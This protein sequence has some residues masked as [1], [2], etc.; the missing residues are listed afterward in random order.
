VRFPKIRFICILNLAIL[1]VLLNGGIY[2]F[3][4]PEALFVVPGFA[5]LYSPF[6]ATG[7]AAILLALVI[8][9][10]ELAPEK[11]GSNLRDSKHSL[12]LGLTYGVFSILLSF[13]YTLIVPC[14]F[15]LITSLT[16]LADSWSLS[17]NKA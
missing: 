9:F 13:Q 7:A 8:A 16:L 12:S 10:V 17:Q 6:S 3:A 14:T 4:C 5:K 2:S 1:K 15:L 11:N